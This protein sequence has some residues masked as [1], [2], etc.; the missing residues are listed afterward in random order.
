[1]HLNSS[2]TVYMNVYIPSH[3]DSLS[4][5]GD[6]IDGCCELFLSV[7]FPRYQMSLYAFHFYSPLLTSTYICYFILCMYNRFYLSMSQSIPSILFVPAVST[8]IVLPQSVFFSL[9]LSFFPKD[10]YRELSQG[11]L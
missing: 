1:L 11:P 8:V 10:W 6:D 9:T 4:L 2:Y 5:K 3:I 7:T